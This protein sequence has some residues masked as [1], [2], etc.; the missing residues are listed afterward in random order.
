MFGKSWGKKK[1]K[2]SVFHVTN[3]GKFRLGEPGW[4]IQVIFN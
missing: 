2:N 1:T 3:R 4:E